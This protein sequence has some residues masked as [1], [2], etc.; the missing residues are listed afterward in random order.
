MDKILF[1]SPFMYSTFWL[2]KYLNAVS[3]SNNPIRL[4]HLQ[5]LANKSMLHGLYAK[6][7]AKTFTVVLNECKKILGCSSK[8]EKY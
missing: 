3:Y 7:M 6:E 5:K 8:T 1:V 2:Y 4:D